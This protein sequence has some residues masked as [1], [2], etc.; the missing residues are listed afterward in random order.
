MRKA[1]FFCLLAVL[2]TGCKTREIV[3]EVVR[4]DTVFQ[5][6]VRRD[7]VY[8][9]DSVYVSEK[10]RNDTVWLTTTRWRTQYVDRLKLD[11]VYRS[12]VDSVCREVVNEVPA[13]LTWWQQA[14]LHIA[15]IL[16]YALGIAAIIYGVKWYLKLKE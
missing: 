1:L 3:T 10:Q 11:T 15:N 13:R 5:N 7:S 8:L 12:R 9:H 4:T 14:R 16:L 6:H 2:L